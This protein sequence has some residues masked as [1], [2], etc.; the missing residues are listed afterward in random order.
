MHTHT[1]TLW[2]DDNFLHVDNVG[3]MEVEEDADLT[4]RSHGEPI[5]LLLHLH[6]FQRHNSTCACVR[7]CVR[8]C[9]RVCVC[10]CV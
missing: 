3:V 5:L 9:V 8:V 2:A 7:A 10:V 4:Y 6:T 1:Y